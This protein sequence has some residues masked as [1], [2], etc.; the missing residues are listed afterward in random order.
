M[1]PRSFPCSSLIPPSSPPTSPFPGNLRHPLWCS[2]ASEDFQSCRTRKIRVLCAGLLSNINRE[3]CSWCRLAGTANRLP[4]WFAVWKIPS[5]T[6]NR[7]TLWAQLSPAKWRMR[8]YIL[9]LADC[10]FWWNFLQAK[11]T[12]RRRRSI[13]ECNGVAASWRCVLL[14]RDHRYGLL[15]SVYLSLRGVAL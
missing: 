5:S 4:Q 9:Y 11:T 3:L 7:T 13:G 12:A 15:R 2:A 14:Y 8:F 6:G 10:A 1:H